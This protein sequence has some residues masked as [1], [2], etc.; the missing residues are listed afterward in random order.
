VHS[1]ASHVESRRNARFPAGL[2]MLLDTVAHRSIIDC[3]RAIGIVLVICFH[4][5]VGTASLLEPADLPSYVA[6]IPQPLNVLW[7]ALGSELVFL[8]SSFLL[9]YLLMREVI[10]HGHIDL[11][12]FYM[13]RVSRILP[14]YA[15]ALALYCFMTDFTARDFVLNMLFISRLFGATTIIP[16]GW[17]LE[18]LM[19]FFLILPF[20]ILGALRSRIPVT[21]TLLAMLLCLAARYLT[22]TSDPDS[23]RTPIYLMLS[24]SETPDSLDDLYYQLYYRANPFLLGFLMAYLVLHRE[25]LLYRL[26]ASRLRTYAVIAVAAVLMVA[27]G[28]LPIQDARS[29]LYTRMGDEFWLWFWVIHR[30]LFAI[31]VGLF[32]LAMWY[33]K[34]RLLQPFHW[35]AQLPVWH[36]ISSNIYSIYLFHPIFLIPAA[37]IGFHTIHKKD[38][39]PVHLWEVLVVIV[40]ATVFSN[41]FASLLTRYVEIP[42]RDWLRKR[43][44]SLGSR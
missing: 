15:L 20:F 2:T 33:G 5:T 1:A 19:Q 27:S 9:S 17:S 31:G 39:M 30:F 3:I 37:V 42:A 8:F 32:A 12:R 13:R 25:G 16:V 21:L 36:T 4:V 10:R 35:F 6:A 28:F 43:S 14:M 23:Y 7:Q 41:A 29:V 40:L 22:L 24:G 34:S 38:L 44:G 11:R 26:F 18:V